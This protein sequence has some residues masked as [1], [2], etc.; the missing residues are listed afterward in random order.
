MGYLS[1]VHIAALFGR[2]KCFKHLCEN[3]HAR[4]DATDAGGFTPFLFAAWTGSRELL[5]YIMSRDG[6]DLTHLE[7]AGTPPLTSSCGGKGP[8]I[9]YVWA[10][11]KGFVD[12]AEAIFRRWRQI[13]LKAQE[14]VGGSRSEDESE[15]KRRQAQ[16]SLALRGRLQ[17]LVE[18]AKDGNPVVDS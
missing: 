15:V 2:L 9:G 12:V 11:R 8:Y 6:F 3:E 1:A 5:D 7:A 18:A 4:I 17:G 13:N 14:Q 16:V 10:H